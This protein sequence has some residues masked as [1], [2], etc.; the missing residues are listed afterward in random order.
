[1]KCNVRLSW[2][3]SQFC[4]QHSS[5]DATIQ[6]RV[7]STDTNGSD[8]NI[9]TKPLDVKVTVNPV[10]EIVGTADL[11]MTDGHIYTTAGAEDTWYTLGTDS[12]FDLANDWTN[13]DAD[14]LTYAHLTPELV[15]GIAMR[16]SSDHNSN[17]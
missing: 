13:Q 14:E 17:G 12:G 8:T 9:Q 11:T 5:Q 6:V 3:V 4:R 1:M 15:S 7:T 10:A 2:T 16:Q